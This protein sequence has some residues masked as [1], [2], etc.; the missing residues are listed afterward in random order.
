MTKMLLSRTAIGPT[1]LA[2]GARTVPVSAC[3]V[4]GGTAPATARHQMLYRAMTTTWAAAAPP[5]R[6]RALASR[7]STTCAQLFTDM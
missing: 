7:R 5:T 6:E 1:E 2:S 4:A 3:K